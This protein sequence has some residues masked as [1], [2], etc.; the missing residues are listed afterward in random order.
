MK[1]LGVT[2]MTAIDTGIKKPIDIIYTTSKEFREK[3]ENVMDIYH[4]LGLP[5]CLFNNKG[6]PISVLPKTILKNYT[7]KYSFNA[8]NDN[9]NGWKTGV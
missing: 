3:L 5:V 7:V 6:K 1:E 8:I 2:L 9:M 4:R